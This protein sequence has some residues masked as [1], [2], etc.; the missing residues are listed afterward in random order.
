M[1]TENMHASSKDQ[2][3]KAH[4]E[5]L[6][7]KDALNVDPQNSN[8]WALLAANYAEVHDY[9]MAKKCYA[10][11]LELDPAFDLIR[12]QLGLLQLCLAEV[13]A[14][15]HTWHPL[16]QLNE[17]DPLRMFV[18]GIQCLLRDQFSDALT[19][20]EKGIAHN[21]HNHELNHDM[22]SMIERIKTIERNI[23]SDAVKT[24]NESQGPEE[25]MQHF[26]VSG[27]GKGH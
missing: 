6:F 14:S 19:W 13:E 15:Q 20:L 1:M 4:N 24:V 2:M 7:L 9:Q 27:Y 3:E 10:S 16:E 22:R 8:N 25:S 17:A 12:F 23:S 21:L 5:I 26:L 11:A 18:V